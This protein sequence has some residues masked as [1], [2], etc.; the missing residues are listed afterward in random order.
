MMNRAN[1]TFVYEVPIPS[2]K[3]KVMFREVN[4]SQQ[5]RLIKAIIDS[6]AYNTEFIF[7]LFVISNIVRLLSKTA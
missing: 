5:K 1:E 2:L 6:P 7:A 3:R 4:T